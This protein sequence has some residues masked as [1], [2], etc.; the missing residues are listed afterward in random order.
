[1]V[2]YDGTGM[3][4]AKCV[5]LPSPDHVH[6]NDF[7]LIVSDSGKSIKLYRYNGSSF[8]DVYKRQSNDLTSPWKL[9]R[10]R[11][12]ILYLEP[13]RI[14]EILEGMFSQFSTDT[15]AAK[16]FTMG[17]YLKLN[18]DDS[19]EAM[20]IACDF[21]RSLRACRKVGEVREMC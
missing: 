6:S 10:L 9:E 7:H 18:S 8:E 19:E 13:K 21:F 5:P 4:E 1:M 3:Q 14:Q 16:N 17:L 11:E 2:N 20:E 12:E 15:E